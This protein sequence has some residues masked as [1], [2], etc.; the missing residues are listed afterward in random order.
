MRGVTAQRHPT[1]AIIP[2]RGV[3]PVRARVEGELCAGGDGEA[4]GAPGFG[5]FGCALFEEGQAAFET[6]EIGVWGHRGVKPGLQDLKCP[7]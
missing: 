1:G 5:V 6:G 7:R 2:G 3:A 4:D